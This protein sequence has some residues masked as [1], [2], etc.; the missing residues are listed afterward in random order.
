MNYYEVLQI[1]NN[2]SSQ[3]IKQAYRKLAKKYHPDSQN[4]FANH[5]EIIRLNAAYEVLNNPEQRHL[6][7][8][9]LGGNSVTAVKY[10]EEKSNDASRYYQEN[11]Q[12]RRNTEVYQTQW[13][14]EVY[15]P[16]NQLINSIIEPLEMEIEELSADVF[17]D[18]LMDFFLGYLAR[19]NETYYQANNLLA[20]QPNP[21]LYAG[22][23]QNLYYS[24]NHVS[25][26]L[27]ELNRFTQTYDETYL[28]TGR[29]LFNLADETSILAR[30][31]VEKFI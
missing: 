31:M 27:E 28:H 22:I 2:A 1:K 17:D 12:R 15:Y 7:D 29:E 14:N 25:D 6:Y 30:E 5:E 10:R 16:I 3:E 23:A 18:E 8:R 21:S 4:D 24:L 11:R 20:S 9:T 19:C 13:L 26:G